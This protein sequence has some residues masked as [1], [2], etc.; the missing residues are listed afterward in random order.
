MEVGVAFFIAYFLDPALN[1]HHTFHLHPMKLQGGIGI[2]GQ[3]LPL[4]ALV[5]AEP[6]NTALIEALDQHHA[7]AR[8]QV[9]GDRSHRH[10]I[11]LGHLA[12]DRF[13]QPLAKL[14]QGVG[15]RGV[16]TEFS[17]LVTFSEVGNRGHPA[18][19]DRPS[20]LGDHGAGQAR[21]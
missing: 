9:A 7:G 13:V 16:F 14:Q 1:A 10:G 6:H 4:A 20:T 11:G 15:M 5:V 2:A 8:A 12:R 18:S 21:A 19:I 17:A 3:L